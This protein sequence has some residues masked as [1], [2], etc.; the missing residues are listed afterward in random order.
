MSQ[1]P[2]ILIIIPT[3]NRNELL[4]RAVQS[5][6]SQ[7]YGNTRVLVIDDGSDIPQKDF[8]SEEL[9]NPRLSSIR[10]KSNINAY[11]SRNLGVLLS[12]SAEAFFFLDSDDIIVEDTI[13]KMAGQMFVL[14]EKP[15]PKF[16]NIQVVSSLVKKVGL[17]GNEEIFGVTY[18]LAV[19]FIPNIFDDSPHGRYLRTIGSLYKR[20]VFEQ[21]GGF[22][23][24]P[25]AADDDLR[26]RCV[27]VGFRYFVINEPLYIQYLQADSLT[28]NTVTGFKT[29]VRRMAW[30]LIAE[31]KKRIMKALGTK[32][33]VELNCL[34][35]M[36]FQAFE[37]EETIN[38]PD[39][40]VNPII[41]IDPGSQPHIDEAITDKA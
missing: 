20:E 28:Q 8:I 33:D 16:K 2:E 36:R 30:K 23:D 17:D 31:R 35:P 34:E 18:H 39:L 25:I 6:L 22:L 40:K 15:E 37:I 24:I 29:D 5:A 14:P 41:P 11:R 1:L 7:T 13:E 4:K 3:K 21:I 12:P 19:P 26:N 38:I 9:Q 10:L 32:V 27:A